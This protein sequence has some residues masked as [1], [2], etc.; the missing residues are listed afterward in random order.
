M[1]AALIDNK[2][3]GN[4]HWWPKS[5]QRH[6]VNSNGQLHHKKD[7]VVTLRNPKNRRTGCKRNAHFVD[8]GDSPWTHSFEDAFSTI[9][10]N[11]A[12]AVDAAVTRIQQC[13]SYKLSR[14]K[15]TSWLPF[16][17][18]ATDRKFE[19]LS[20]GESHALARLSIAIVVRSPAFQFRKS[21]LHPAFF[22]NGGIHSLLGQ[23][24]IWQYWSD[25]YRDSDL[26]IEPISIFFLIAKKTHEFVI[27][28]GFYENIIDQ[29]RLV[30]SSPNGVRPFY[31]GEV[32]FPL[33]PDV[34]V[35]ICFNSDFGQR[36]A[37]L[38]GE[39]TRQINRITCLSSRREIYFRHI[40]VD[41]FVSPDE[42]HVRQ[43]S[44]RQEFFLNSLIGAH[45]A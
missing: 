7:G 25:L 36:L 32:L 1:P 45:A 2:K 13:P 19:C 15:L 12:A 16:A 9:D 21:L 31:D 14:A 29:Q 43:V 28:D 3:R 10:S 26:P 23:Q 41:E 6:W 42:V 4:H 24:N 44:L 38:S 20:V 17:S 33:S 22:P 18:K 27:G 39:E 40:D 34:C 37:I 35:L 11:G 5:I 30:E 8:F